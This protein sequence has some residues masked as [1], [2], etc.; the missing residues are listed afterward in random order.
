[1]F[2]GSLSF[3]YVAGAT[4]GELLLEL[5][6]IGSIA[7]LI[8]MIMVGGAIELMMPRSRSSWR[9]AHGI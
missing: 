4:G 5:W 6:G 8:A 1:V 7:L 2:A 9:S 3:S